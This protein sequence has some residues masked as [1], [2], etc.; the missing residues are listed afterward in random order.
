MRPGIHQAV[1]DIQAGRPRGLV[2]LP[3]QAKNDGHN[4]LP[5]PCTGSPDVAQS[6]AAEFDGALTG[7]KGRLREPC[8]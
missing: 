7:V 8:P 4:V 5:Q 3:V 2:T 1:D 6:G